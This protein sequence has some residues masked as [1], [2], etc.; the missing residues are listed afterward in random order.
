MGLSRIAHGPGMPLLAI[1]P[2]LVDAFLQAGYLAENQ[3]AI[4]DSA[5]IFNGVYNYGY[6]AAFRKKV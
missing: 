3:N 6:L 4:P 1:E 5:K 2:L